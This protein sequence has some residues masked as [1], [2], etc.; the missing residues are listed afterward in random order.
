MRIIGPEGL[1]AP[2]M[3]R[4]EIGRGLR[5]DGGGLA[6]GDPHR[7][8]PFHRRRDQA[9]EHLHLSFGVWLGGDGQELGPVDQHHLLVVARDREIRDEVQQVGL[10]LPRR[11]HRL[12]RDA[13]LAGDVGHRRGDVAAGQ[14]E[15]ACGFDDAPAGRRAFLGRPFAPPTGVVRA[16]SRRHHVA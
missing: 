4:D 14:E 3:G 9:R 11:V 10:A 16:L 13:G 7:R 1:A 12:Q 15:L 8:Q 5:V 6:V 2:A